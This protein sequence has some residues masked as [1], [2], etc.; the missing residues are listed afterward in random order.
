MASMLHQST[1]SLTARKQASREVGCAHAIGS[2]TRRSVS[3]RQA[4]SCAPPPCN[5]RAATVV[6]GVAAA[7][8]PAAATSK[9]GTKQV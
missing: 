8:T 1:S 2:Q 4:F 6:R 3:T 5:Q 9:A 7:A